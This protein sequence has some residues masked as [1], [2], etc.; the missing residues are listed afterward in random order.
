MLNHPKFIPPAAPP[1]ALAPPWKPRSAALLALKIVAPSA[2]QGAGTQ[3]CWKGRGVTSAVAPAPDPAISPGMT[4]PVKPEAR[5]CCPPAA[6]KAD[7]RGERTAGAA[8]RASG[9]VIWFARISP[10]RVA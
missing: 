4:M 10:L 5:R 9:K 6:A 8:A 2:V 7:E 3:V 1:I